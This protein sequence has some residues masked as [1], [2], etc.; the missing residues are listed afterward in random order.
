MKSDADSM[1]FTSLSQFGEKSEL[2]RQSGAEV[3]AHSKS[4]ELKPHQM[5]GFDGHPD[6]GVLS[7]KDRALLRPF[8]SPE[9]V[10]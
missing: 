10:H 2:T 7:V 6:Q 3:V 5:P 1:D 8:P 4:S 9:H